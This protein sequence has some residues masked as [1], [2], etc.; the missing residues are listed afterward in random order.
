VPGALIMCSFPPDGFDVEGRTLVGRVIPYMTA[1]DVVDAG[2]VRAE[3]V[4]PGAFRRSISERADRIP[5]LAGHPD[6]R[7]LN[8]AMPIGRSV[9]WDDQPDALYGTFRLADTASGRDAGVLIAD[10]LATGLSVGFYPDPGTVEDR[11]G[12]IT[13]RT[14]R[15]HHVALVLEGAYPGAEVLS[16]RARV[17]ATSGRSIRPVVARLRALDLFTEGD[18]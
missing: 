1:G 10:G 5:L 8:S 16:V 7:R 3:Q 11:A 18:H 12:V 13:H 17:E 14:G 6:E 4:A 15:L 2:E 9:A